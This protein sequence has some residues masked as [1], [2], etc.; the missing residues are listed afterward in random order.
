MSE[1]I[2]PEELNN[3]PSDVVEEAKAAYDGAVFVPDDLE[4]I[5]FE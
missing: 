1:N 2:I 3:R 5:T 4:T